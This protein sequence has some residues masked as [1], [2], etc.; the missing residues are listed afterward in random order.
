MIEDISLLTYTH[1]NCS[2][3]HK[4]YFDS[5]DLF[6]KPKKNYVLVDRPIDGIS[7]SQIIYNENDNFSEQMLLGLSNIDTQYLIY[8][9]EDYILYDNVNLELL[10]N[11]INLLNDDKNIMFVR[12]ISAGLN[13]N[14]E[15]YNEDYVILDNNNDYFYSSQITLWR[16]ESLIDMF[17]FSN[18]KYIVDEPK[19]SPF[20]KNIGGIGLCTTLKGD[21]VGGHHNS[22]I[23]PYIATAI[24]KGK[25]NFSEYG[26][27]LENLLSKYDIDK[28][29]RNII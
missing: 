1:S 4:M 6:F 23:Y 14:E 29:K 28:Y 18:V 8:S 15:K 27:K 19:N 17:K 11:S 21:K 25:W 9:Q 16:K 7:V 5:I 26:D 3:L 24:N 10:I 20:L 2:D 13:G 22:I 12:L